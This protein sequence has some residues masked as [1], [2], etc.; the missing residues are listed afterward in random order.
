[1][2]EFRVERRAD[3]GSWDGVV[4]RSASTSSYADTSVSPSTAYEYRIRACGSAGCCSPSDASPSTA[5][6]VAEGTRQPSLVVWG[7]IDDGRSV[8]RPAF[9]IETLP[10]LPSEPGPYSLDGLDANGA[11]L[12]SYSFQGVEN[13]EEDGTRSF[14][15]AIP[16][17]SI[18]APDL[19]E[20]QL[21][22]G[23]LVLDRQERAAGPAPAPAPAPA[24][25]DVETRLLPGGQTVIEWDAEANP[26]LVARD[27]TTGRILSLA[28]GG[29]VTLPASA[30]GELELVLSDGVRSQRELRR[31]E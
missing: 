28:Q 23:G 4:T 2:E 12:F 3:G 16:L 25:R 19:A 7:V 22:R 14:A 29:S 18:A 9:E 1:M 20:L 31:P 21:R 11:V 24:L 26:L 8:L 10:Q 15:L 5:T 17:S 13:G 30:T 6:F 27:P